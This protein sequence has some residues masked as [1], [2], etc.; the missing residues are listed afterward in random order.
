MVLPSGRGG[1][2]S[3]VGGG[4]G[5]PGYLPCKTFSGVR[6]GYY[7]RLDAQGPGYY[8]DK[9]ASSYA[10]H[11][12]TEEAAIKRLKKEAAAKRVDP[13]QLLEVGPVEAPPGFQ[14]LICEKDDGAFK[15]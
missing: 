12:E 5:K 14:S 9:P 10:A 1:A 3:S 11:D 4:E 15:L 13:R 8:V 2:P 7:F 6:P